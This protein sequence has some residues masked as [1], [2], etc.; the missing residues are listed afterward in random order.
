MTELIL[1]RHG[2]ACF[3][4]DE[5]DRLSPLGIQQVERLAAHLAQSPT[6]PTT[7]VHGSLRRQRQT[8]DLILQG[9]EANGRRLALTRDDRLDEYDIAGVFWGYLDDILA[10]QPD[11][12]PYRDRLNEH[13][14][15]FETVYRA[16]MQTWIADATP[17]RRGLQSWPE[18]QQQ[19]RDAFEHIRDRAGDRVLV[20]TSGAVIASLLGQALN[21]DPAMVLGLNS[22]LYNSSLTRFLVID[23][24]LVLT[25]FNTVPHLQGTGDRDLHSKR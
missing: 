5:Y 11:L 24:K 19:V 4:T 3:G 21:L 10:Q 17:S 18:F 22:G 12:A 2:Q 14:A 25:E 15:V 13:P 6:P 23:G 1:I 16:I 20:V 7:L 8:A 9:L